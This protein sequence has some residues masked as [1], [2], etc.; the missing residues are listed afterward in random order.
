MDLTWRSAL[1]N[2]VFGC[3]MSLPALSS[4][5]LDGHTV[6]TRRRHPNRQMNGADQQ[7]AADVLSQLSGERL[8]HA[9]MP[10]HLLSEWQGEQRRAE[11]AR[12][13]IQRQAEAREQ[14]LA[15][16]G[17]QH[18]TAHTVLCRVS[19]FGWASAVVSGPDGYDNGHHPQYTSLQSLRIEG[20][21]PSVRSLVYL[22]PSLV[23]LDTRL[24]VLRRQN[25][26]EEAPHPSTTALR[27]LKTSA[28][29]RNLPELRTLE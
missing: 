25:Q 20:D 26:R 9:T 17:D 29:I 24:D 13:S 8:I 4:L 6:R 1:V 2:G 7:F 19:Y 10:G 23:L 11:N 15:Q 21:G 14:A 3:L 28:H 27:F 18:E 22:F 5:V 16:M 12:H